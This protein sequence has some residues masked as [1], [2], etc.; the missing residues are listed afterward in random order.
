MNPIKLTVCCILGWLLCNLQDLH[1]Q[2]PGLAPKTTATSASDTMVTIEILPG[3][4]KLEFRKLNDTTQIQILAGDVKLRQGK[5]LFYCD[6][7]VINNTSKTFEAWGNVHINDSDTADVYSNHL[8]YYSNRKYAYLDGNVKLTDGQGVLTTPNLEYDVET[9]IGIYRNGGRV[10]NKQ[11]VVTSREGYYYTDLK[12]VYFKQNVELKDPVYYLK[13]D[14]ILYNTENEIARFIAQTRIE[15]TTGRTIDTRDG[16]YNLKTGQAEFGRNPVIKDGAVTI[17]GERFATDSLG[18]QQVEGNAIIHD[19]AQGTTIIGGII[20]RNKNT[21]AILATRKP[22]MIIKQENDSIYVTADTLFSARLTDLYTTKENM[23]AK[24]SLRK[25]TLLTKDS[26][27]VSDS[28]IRQDTLVKNHNLPRKD[29]LIKSDTLPQQRR[30]LVNRN[31]T[32]A[33]K[34]SLRRQTDIATKTDTL[35]KDTLK[36]VTVLD[37][38]KKDSTNR[39]FEAYR[40]VRIF[41]DS[42]QGVCDSL[43][44]SFKDSIFRMFYDPILWAKESQITGDTIRLFTK[45]KKADKIE[46][47]NKSF[48]VNQSDPEIFNQI[49]ASRMDGWFVDGN[50]DSIRARGLAECI[51]YI[52]DEDSAYTGINESKSE[53]MDIYFKNKE[54]IKVVFRTAVTGT[55]WPMSQ[56]KPEE[57]RLPEF[58]WL[59]ERRPK[60][61]YEL[62]E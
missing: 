25:D 16:F 28:L 49:K 43:F 48:L 24:D 26:L 4:R 51:Y 44:Y 31:D 10:V 13:T 7:C 23:L 2:L 12:D 53:V 20:F 60:T 35:I 52:Q 6:S 57:M 21:E 50:M 34:D 9:K 58:R 61:K 54:L 33:S 36:G 37:T 15:D 30:D 14:S 62:F 11:T 39:Y 18:N 46:V 3:V 17:T 55:M 56:K 47:V 1:A 45:N 29:S 32:L 41:S 40:N 59:E 22:L 38:K 19:S 42:L 8:L 5:T 27:M